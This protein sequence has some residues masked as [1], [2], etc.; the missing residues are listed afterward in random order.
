MHLQD[1][2]AAHDVRVR[3]HDLPVETARAQQRRVEHVR[4]VRGGDQD[5]AFIGLEAVHFDEQLVEGLFAFVIAA[6]KTCTT[7]PANGVDFID[8][9]DARRVLLGL[10]EH[11]AHTAGADTHEHF[12]EIGAR[13]REERHIGLSGDRP[14]QQRLTGAR[15]ADQQHA[16]RDATA[17]TL[18]LLR[19]AQEVDDFLEIFLCLIHTGHVLERHPAVGFR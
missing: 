12:N 5:D 17:Q 16:T 9:D 7:V 13:D 3:H 2:F 4:T 18:E 6:A 19:I 10:L 11:V 1:L 15:R 14:C 8:E